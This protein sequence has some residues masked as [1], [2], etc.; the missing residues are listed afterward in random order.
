MERPE[1]AVDQVVF[2]PD[3]N[4]ER[5]DFQLSTTVCPSFSI[6]IITICGS[7]RG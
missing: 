1:R 7:I 6:Q 2:D 3:N 4:S 5:C